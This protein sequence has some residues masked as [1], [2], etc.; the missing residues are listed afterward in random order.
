[1]PWP[2]VA[3]PVLV[4]GAAIVAGVVGAG[5]AIKGAVDMKDANDTLKSARRQHESNIAK[6]ETESQKTTTIMDALGTK[7]LN[8][9][10]S[11]ENFSMLIEQIHNRPE[12]INYNKGNVTLPPYN[13]ESLRD[14]SVGAGV[15]I[16]GLGGAALGTASGF[17][18]A[19]A[20]TAAV[21]A[22]GTASTGTAIAT[23]SGV[24]A[25]NATLAALGGGAIAAGGGGIVAGTA[26]LGAATLGVGLLIG[27]IVFSVTG[28]KISEKADE[29]YWQMKKAEGEITK[30]CDYLRSLADTATIFDRSLSKVQDIYNDHHAALDTLIQQDKK[31]DWE[32]YSQNEKMLVENTALLVGLLYKMCKVELVLKGEDDINIV[33]TNAVNTAIYEADTVLTDANL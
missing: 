28:S 10:A 22:L 4:K 17:A 6:F 25:T 31:T 21:M 13:A 32:E 8:I 1:M 15:L 3:I 11:F 14:V 33:N 26:V 16:G 12:F 9:L 30:I 2:F 23:L 5:A 27:G 24:A 20:T 29:A 7:E 18:A 19:G